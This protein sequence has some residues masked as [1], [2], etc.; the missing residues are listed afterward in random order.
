MNI[1]IIFT[2]YKL[3]YDTSFVKLNLKAEFKYLSRLIDISI[4][5]I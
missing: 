2:H 1:K 3:Y 5:V 4:T